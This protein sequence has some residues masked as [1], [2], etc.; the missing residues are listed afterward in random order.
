MPLHPNPFPEAS[1]CE[2]KPLQQNVPVAL[3]PSDL[4]IAPEAF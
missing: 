3:E 4:P 1:V 2:V